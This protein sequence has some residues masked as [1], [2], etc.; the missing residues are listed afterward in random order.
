MMRDME[1]A[2]AARLA[3][4][5]V[6]TD[7]YRAHYA[8][9]QQLCTQLV[10]SLV[11]ALRPHLMTAFPVEA[12]KAGLK[13][14]KKTD[15][16]LAAY[17]AWKNAAVA[18]AVSAVYLVA[19]V[20]AFVRL[21]NALH[22]RY[23]VTDEH[24]PAYP[25]WAVTVAQQRQLL[26]NPAP[27]ASAPAATP[28]PSSDPVAGSSGT[29]VVAQAAS[30]TDTT[31]QQAATPAAAAVD[32]SPAYA[33]L[34]R[35]AQPLQ[36]WRDDD[37][38]GAVARRV[39]ES[40]ASALAAWAVTSVV[41]DAACAQCI[42]EMRAAVEAPAGS[43]MAMLRSIVAAAR[44]SEPDPTDA[45]QTRF[46]EM[47][48]ELT[49]LLESPSFAAALALSV[50]R[51]FALLQQQWAPLFDPPATATATATVTE[52]TDDTPKAVLMMHVATKMALAGAHWL[53]E[54]DS[55]VSPLL[56]ALQ[57][58]ESAAL[59]IDS[60]CRIVYFPLHRSLAIDEATLPPGRFAPP[61]PAP[62]PDELAAMLRSLERAPPGPAPTGAPPNAAPAAASAATT[63]AD[64]LHAALAGLQ[65]AAG[66]V[67]TL[68]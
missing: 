13:R 33:R 55:A 18:R 53:P 63:R 38:L 16:D 46:L 45:V 22:A 48:S 1:Q 11:S 12:M 36:Q 2:E 19:V 4:H 31:V 34:L 68:H 35:L 64:D 54:S 57:P 7:V 52:V 43:L 21:L 56:A 25:A 51:G 59:D 37:G 61:P 28:Q 17:E 5:R 14:G 60:V 62:P 10:A 39:S 26:A 44:A 49:L 41:D 9:N 47:L 27:P 20:H 8:H 65:G 29:L 50:D 30:S 66:T 24:C 58:A 3:E 40:V 15:A 23:V 6:R 32:F 42:R 67:A